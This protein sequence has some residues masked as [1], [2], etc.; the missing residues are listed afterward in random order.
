MAPKRGETV[1][2]L[3][4]RWQSEWLTQTSE[5]EL[6]DESWQVSDGNWEIGSIITCFE[7]QVPIAE[8]GTRW[9]PF[10]CQGSYKLVVDDCPPRSKAP[11]ARSP[12]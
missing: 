11:P 1:D 6:A 5:G 2:E 9:V 4:A 7:F 12:R 3:L 10:G 8:P